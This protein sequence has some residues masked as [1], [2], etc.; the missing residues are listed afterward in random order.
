[1]VDM[2]NTLKNMIKRWSDSMSR[3]FTKGER[4]RPIVTVEKARKGKPTVIN[5]S[6][7]RYI[8]DHKYAFRR[9]GK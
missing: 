7:F 2:R 1:M 5:V 6:G 4:Y 9:N 3:K 8:L